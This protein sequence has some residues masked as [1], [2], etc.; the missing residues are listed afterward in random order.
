[1]NEQQIRALVQQMLQQQQYK[2]SPTSYHTH[3]GIDSPKLTQSSVPSSGVSS[4]IAG[5]NITLTP[6][7]GIGD[8]TVSAAG[9]TYP[10]TSVSGSGSGINVS[11]TTGAIVVSNT[12]VTSL[13]A[14]TNISISGP[15]GAITVS[16]SA[17]GAVSA[18]GTDTL[19][20]ATTPINTTHTITHGLGVTPIIIS[21]QVPQLLTPT[22]SG[23]G[24]NYAAMNGWL[25]FNGSAVVIGGVSTTYTVTTGGGGTTTFSSAA[26]G[27]SSISSTGAT[28][29]GTG[30]ASITI[31]NVTST[32]FDIVYTGSQSSGSSTFSF[33]TVSWLALA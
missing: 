17:G 8:V 15:T 32:T 24:T 13:V 5:S 31:N 2:V 26:T 28:T 16:S 25:Y 20:G 19:S 30:A 6:V 22:P 14:G 23:S 9:P 18:T 12:G 7:T 11:P 4:L 29:G 27:P 33:P 1:M 10:V 3:N 21:M